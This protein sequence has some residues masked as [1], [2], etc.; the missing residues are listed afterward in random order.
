LDQLR[1]NLDK[2]WRNQLNAAERNQFN[3]CV[4]SDS[5]T[6]RSFCRLYVQMRERKHFQTSVDIEEF[7][8]MQDQLPDARKMKV[9]ICKQGDE[10]LAGLVASALGDSAIYLLGATSDAAMRLKAA[11]ELQWTLIRLLKEQGIRY[12]DLGGT[13]PEANPGTSRAALAAWKCNTSEPSQPAAANSAQLPCGRASCCAAD[14]TTC[15]SA[16]HPTPVR[17]VR[18][19]GYIRHHR[20][21]ECSRLPP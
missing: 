19:Y 9:L 1:K 16:S 10:P 6:Y 13:D 12:Y 20:Q 21:L 15:V 14:C 3:V 17:A 11:Y 8:R 5:E 4:G 7:G 18:T 2:K